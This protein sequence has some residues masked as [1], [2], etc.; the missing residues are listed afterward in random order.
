MD[1]CTTLVSA[2]CLHKPEEG[3]GFLQTGVTEVMSFS[4]CAGF[5]GRATSALKL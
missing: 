4:I 5:S 3:V 1:I 2:W